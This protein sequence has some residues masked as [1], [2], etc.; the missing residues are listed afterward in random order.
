MFLKISHHYPLSTTTQECSSNADQNN[1][2]AD[3]ALRT[4]E[5]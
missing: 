5:V 1:S 2:E 4:R 3:T